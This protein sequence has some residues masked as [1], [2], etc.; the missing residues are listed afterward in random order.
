[1][2]S[3]K[4]RSNP[5]GKRLHFEDCEFDAIAE[6]LIERAGGDVFAE[7]D[8]VDVDLVLLKALDV[9]ADYGPLPE[10]IMGR[11]L[12]DKS[13]AA[14][15][16]VSSDLAEAAE[17]DRVAR[18]RLRTTLAH[19]GGHVS[20]HQSLFIVDS[21]TFDL[22][23]DEE[24]EPKPAIMCREDSISRPRYRGDWWEY[25]ANQVMAALLLPKR[26]FCPN[27]E[28]A[29][30]S[31]GVPDFTEAIKRDAHENVLRCLADMF[32][33]S[34]EATFYRLQS[35]GFAPNVDEKRFAL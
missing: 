9:E 1:M 21:D 29:L 24:S 28:R 33:V 11:T 8:G 17:I 23:P 34:W 16:Q 26:W 13:G 6:E 31:F 22:F 32:D 19:E 4:D 20:C 27:V 7:G 2:K 35:L 15:I 30:G 5:W 14:C 18:R 10:G 25:Q 3:W 12:F